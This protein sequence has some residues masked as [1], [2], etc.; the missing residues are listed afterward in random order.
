V[1]SLF[2]ACSKHR[3]ALFDDVPPPTRM[4]D[5]KNVADSMAARRAAA[6]KHSKENAALPKLSAAR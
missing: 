3:I 4:A 5:Q 2:R 6:N 1:A